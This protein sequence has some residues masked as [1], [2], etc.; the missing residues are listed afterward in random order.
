MMADGTMK[1]YPE[2]VV[3]HILL[4]LPV[5]FLL[6][7]KCVSKTF[8]TLIKSSNFINL[9]FNHTTLID[10]NILLKRS[11]KED[12]EIYKA[13]FSFLSSDG[14]GYLKSIYPD[15]DLPY[16]KS[17]ISISSDKLIGPIH[18][19]IALMDPITTILF[20]PC[21]R[22]YRLLSSSPFEVPKGFS[23]SIESGGFGFDS[24]VNDF[25][26]FRIVQIYTED[27]YGYD[28]EVEKKVEVYE[29]GIDIWRELDHV[30]PQLPGLF[31]LTSSIFFRGVYH[32]ITTSEEL[33]PII[34][35]FDMSTEIFRNMKPPDTREFSNGTL[36]SL[37]LLTGSLSL[38][39]YP[40]LGPMIDPAKDLIEIWVMKDYNVYESWINKYTVRGLPT[41]S[42]L[43]VWKDYLLFFQSKS[44][45][46][47]SY[48]LN[49]D[50]INELTFHGCLESMRII[51]YNESLTPIP[52]GSQSNSQ[53]QNF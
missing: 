34:L 40:C 43:A 26:I 53:V 6:R 14:D 11:F 46:L 13:I 10:D 24:V 51:I 4:R 33:E 38:I 7:F 5:K 42:P 44:G 25:K 27:R 32:W 30:D 2:D 49:S 16:I 20:N 50:E 41:E 18:G 8:S 19:L 23:I 35:C 45:Y 21:T 39:C 31:W 15:L 3:I 52:R 29:L 37:V 47:M 17:C 9:H 22:N 28:E 12:I 36:H 48:D 1:K